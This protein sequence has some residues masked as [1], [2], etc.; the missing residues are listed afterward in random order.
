MPDNPRTELVRLQ[1][2]NMLLKELYDAVADFARGPHA[3]RSVERLLE[4]YRAVRSMRNAAHKP[5][6]IERRKDTR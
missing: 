5:L 6:P 2:E 4:T 3:P 1:A